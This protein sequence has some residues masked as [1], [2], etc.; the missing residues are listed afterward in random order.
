MLNF[1][2]NRSLSMHSAEQSD[3]PHP[4]S[5]PNSGFMPQSAAA[6]QS[7]SIIS[8]SDGLTN[9]LGFSGKDCLT[10]V[11]LKAPADLIPD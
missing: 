5:V 6:V 9:L 3:K 11:D 4:A 7:A 10:K 8:L 1:M 2:K